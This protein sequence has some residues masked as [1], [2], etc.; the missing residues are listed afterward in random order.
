M[1]SLGSCKF[2]DYTFTDGVKEEKNCGL[3]PQKIYKV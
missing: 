3:E 1:S 2:E